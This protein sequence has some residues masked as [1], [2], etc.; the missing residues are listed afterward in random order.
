MRNVLNVVCCTYFLAIFTFHRTQYLGNKK[1][2]RQHQSTV[3]HVF[4]V[5]WKCEVNLSR[6][7]QKNFCLSLGFFRRNLSTTKKILKRKTNMKLCRKKWTLQTDIIDINVKE[8]LF[9]CPG[10]FFDIIVFIVHHHANDRSD[11]LISGHQIIN[12]LTGNFY[13]VW[14]QQ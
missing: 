14:K 6:F 10:S 9:Y 7:R 13:T 3:C 8:I 5:V 11:W 2:G 12:A 4:P 1:H